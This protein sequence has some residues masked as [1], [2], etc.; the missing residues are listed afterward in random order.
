M[1]ETD[2]YQA[3]LSRLDANSPE[4]ALLKIVAMQNKIKLLEERVRP[5]PVV[6]RVV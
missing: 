3:I 1:P 6:G 2:F 4:E 5:Y